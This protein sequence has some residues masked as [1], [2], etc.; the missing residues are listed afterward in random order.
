MTT[1]RAALL[2]ATAAA[3]ALAT[4]SLLG[5]AVP[6]WLAVAAFFGY[7][8]LVTWGVLSPAAEMF[9]DVL[10]HGPQ[11]AKG[12][13]LTFDDGPHP[14]FTRSV[15]RTLDLAA[16]TA[17]FF[18]IGEKA[19][20]YP[21]VLREIVAA[22][23]TVGVH[24]HRHDRALSL[25]SLARVRADLARSV[26]LVERATGARPHLYRPAVGQTNPRIARAAADLGLTLVGW[27]VRGRDG[28]HVAPESVAKRVIARLRHGAI[29]LLHDAAE[30]DDR[31]PAAP[32]AL[33]QI[34]EAMRA[35]AIPTVR[36][37]EWVRKM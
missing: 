22:G 9:A 25:R 17:T 20:R 27:T 16:A 26:E 1:G 7:A 30:K 28:I 13:A 15:L 6:L 31:E 34:L 21:D 19:A 11:D 2:L 36:V 23:H 10:W 5:A 8:G 37:D 14:E 33:P 18:V 12:I 29:V 35:R 32:N 24:G 4:R 3:V